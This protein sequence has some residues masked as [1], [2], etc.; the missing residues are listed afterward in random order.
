MPPWRLHAL[1]IPSGRS[2]SYPERYDRT[3]DQ[4]RDTTLGTRNRNAR[5]STLRSTRL[6]TDKTEGAKHA[7]EI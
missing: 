4:A 7:L 2:R 6:A 1:F 3:S 5:V